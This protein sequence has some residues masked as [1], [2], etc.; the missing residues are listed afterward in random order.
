MQPSTPTDVAQVGLRRE[1]R[2]PNSHLRSVKATE[3]AVPVI[4]G[5]W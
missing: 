1:L 4:K 5:A 3:N 2:F